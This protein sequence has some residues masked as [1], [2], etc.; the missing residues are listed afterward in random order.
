MDVSDVL[1]CL[2]II[3]ILT[4]AGWLLISFGLWGRSIAWALVVFL[5]LVIIAGV[6]NN[7]RAEDE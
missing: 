6:N 7:G 3:T 2:A 5:E 4:L 1:A